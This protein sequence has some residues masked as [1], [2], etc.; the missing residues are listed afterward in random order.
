MTDRI[1][2]YND[3]H[4]D[5][6][7]IPLNGQGINIKAGSFALLTEDDIAFI[8]S[9]CRFDKRLF[10][11]GKLRIDKK[12][13]PRMEEFGVVKSEENFHP[14]AEEIEKYLKGSLANLNKWL[15]TVTDKALLFEVYEKAK[16]ADLSMSKMR[17]IKEFLPD[18]VT[19]E[20]DE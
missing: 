2:V 14:T 16:E 18:A 20:S 3:N 10:G 17:V 11:T 5:V 13:E 9:Q 6:G 1:K 4:F 7:A 8:E 12:D 15:N 19:I